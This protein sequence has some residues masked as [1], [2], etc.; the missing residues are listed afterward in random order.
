MF[1]VCLSL[2][3]NTI[4]RMHNDD[5]ASSQKPLTARGLFSVTA[6]ATAATASAATATDHRDNAFDWLKTRFTATAGSPPALDIAGWTAESDGIKW[7]SCQRN[8]VAVHSTN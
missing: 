7:P 3:E 8:H 4:S 1:T 6:A 2:L 5:G